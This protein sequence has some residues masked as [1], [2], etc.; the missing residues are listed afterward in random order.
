MFVYNKQ[1]SRID[2]AETSQNWCESKFR[3]KYKNRKR[4]NIERNINKPKKIITHSQN[5]LR[6]E[7]WKSKLW[8]YNWKVKIRRVRWR[9]RKNKK[10][11]EIRITSIKFKIFSIQ[12]SEDY[13]RIIKIKM[14]KIFLDSSP[15]RQP[16]E[17]GEGVYESKYTPYILGG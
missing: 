4:V 6:W 3:S 15:H 11:F 12:T 13:E 2:N 10:I 5:E 7:D 16:A 17:K 14:K 1:K 9:I 8:A